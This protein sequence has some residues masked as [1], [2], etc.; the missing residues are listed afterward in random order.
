MGDDPCDKNNGGCSS[1]R[2]CTNTIT[3]AT[4]G[5][6]PKGYH[7][8]GKA[9]EKDTTTTAPQ[10]NCVFCERAPPIAF[11]LDRSGSMAWCGRAPHVNKHCRSPNR[12]FDKVVRE[13]IKMLATMPDGTLFSVQ[14][15]S[16]S[17]LQFNGN[18]YAANSAS[19]RNTLNTWFHGTSRPGGGTYMTTG[20]NYLLQ[21]KGT[22]KTLYLLADGE[23]AQGQA[24]LV[25]AGKSG[26]VPIPRRG[27]RFAHF[28]WWV[29]KSPRTQSGDW[30]HG[31]IH[32]VQCQPRAL[33][34]IMDYDTYIYMI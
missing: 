22:A 7:A 14:T 10:P 30:R 3:V 20:L 29:Q 33:L 4:C 27:R 18:K 13:V 16:Q 1:Q 17:I 12:R 23:T 6:C 9:C 8:K 5:P 26:G 19:M 24:T 28:I 2:T 32:L 21:K 11:M 25:N 34:L 15:F 31:E